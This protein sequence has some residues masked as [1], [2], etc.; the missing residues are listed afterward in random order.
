[1]NNIERLQAWGIPTANA[2]I[3][4]QAARNHDQASGLLWTEELT[5]QEMELRVAALLDI[6]TPT[7]TN[8]KTARVAYG[9]AIQE[10]IETGGKADWTVVVTKMDKLI[11]QSPWSVKDY[12]TFTHE[13]D[14]PAKLDAVGVPKRKKGAK[15]ALAIEVYNRE[16]GTERTRGEWIELLMG[17]VGL[18]KAGAS[19]YYAGLKK[20]TMG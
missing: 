3:A 11:A 5:Q 16:K 20:G 13:S 6:D 8:Y 2:V 7:F 15:K 10:T 17:E 12:E 14:A 9:Y 18:S 1:M 19:T 4:I